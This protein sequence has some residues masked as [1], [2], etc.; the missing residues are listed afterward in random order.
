MQK[1]FLALS[2]ILISGC[3]S[4]YN[5]GANV[6]DNGG[7]LYRPVPKKVA[8]EMK[9]FE[10]ECI[11]AI[12]RGDIEKIN[13]LANP[14]LLNQIKNETL[15]QQLESIRAKFTLSDKFTR[16][17]LHNSYFWLDEMISLDPYKLYDFIAAE[18]EINGK[19][20]IHVLLLIDKKP[21]YK[22]WGFSIH[23]SDP[24]EKKSELTYFAKEIK[25]WWTFGVRPYHWWSFGTQ[26]QQ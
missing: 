10:E 4:L 12:I 22:L 15:Q 25:G 14:L 3:T 11:T 23:P 8:N 2:L 7:A 18:Y 5:I 17:K 21:E 24:N 6:H 16:V 20:N 9:S 13:A 26:H 1:I 19:Q